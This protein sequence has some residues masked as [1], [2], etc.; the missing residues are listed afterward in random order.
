MI[1]NVG[2]FKHRNTLFVSVLTA[3]CNAMVVSFIIFFLI[4]LNINQTVSFPVWIDLH[5]H[6]EVIY[7]W[8]CDIVVAHCWRLHADHIML[9]IVESCFV[10]NQTRSFYFLILFFSTCDI[11]YNFVKIRHNIHA[12]HESSQWV[13]RSLCLVSLYFCNYVK[14]YVKT[15]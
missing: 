4:I 3:T 6:F 10:G 15:N 2:A 9:S 8:L 14:A 12:F 1:H 7:S 11:I 5:Y 13:N